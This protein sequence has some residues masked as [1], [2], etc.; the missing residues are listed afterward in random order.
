[1]FNKWKKTK[2]YLFN[3]L[4]ELPMGGGF[5]PTPAH[6]IF[7]AVGEIFKFLA[8]PAEAKK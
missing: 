2:S 4:G 5:S 8:K 7:L 6:F 3:K 1:M